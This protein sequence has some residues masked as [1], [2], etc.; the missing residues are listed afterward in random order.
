[1]LISMNHMEQRH[2]RNGIK[3]KEENK[4][5]NVRETSALAKEK[6]LTLQKYGVN[7]NTFFSQCDVNKTGII[8]YEDFS[9][10]LIAASAGL[11]GS[12]MKTLANHLDSGKMG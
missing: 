2:Y 6:L 10:S 11:N 1:M 7:L 9:G 5:R 3:V 4:V 12:E 8:S